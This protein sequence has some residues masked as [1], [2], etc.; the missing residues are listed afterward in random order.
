MKKYILLLVSVYLTLNVFGQVDRSKAPEAGP[1]PKVQIGESQSFTLKNGLKVLVVENHKL[2]RLNFTL[3]LINDPILEGDKSGY[4]E[5][6]GDLWGK[7]TQNRNAKKL[8]EE[9]DFIGA[10]LRTDSHKVSIEG[11]SKFKEDM[12]DIFAD[13]VLN[14]AF[15]KEEFDK[16]ILQ[17]Q[18][19]LKLDET[20]PKSILS[21]ISL[22]TMFGHEH[23]YGDIITPKTVDNISLEDCVNYYKTYVHPNHSILVIVGDITLKDAKKLIQKYMGKWKAASIPTYQYKRPEAPKGRQVVF[24]NK[25]AAPQASIQVSYPIDFKRGQSDEIAVTVM[26]QVLGGGGFQGKLIK[27]LRESK[28]YTYGAFSSI[29]TDI[30]DGAGTFSASAEVKT[31]IVDSAL[32]EILF[33]MDNMVKG[34]FSREDIERIKKTMAGSFSRSMES[35][36]TIANFAFSMEKYKLPKDYFTN[37]L[38]NLS[39]VTRE[40]AV[41]A[42]QKYIHPE[43]AYIFVVTDRGQ[44]EKLAKLSSNGQV[45]ELDHLGEPLKAAAIPAGVTSTTVLDKY[46]NAIGGKEK[47]NGIKDLSIT[48]EMNVQGMTLTII[49]RHILSAG[50]PMFSTSTYMGSNLIQKIS[51]D[52]EKAITKSPAGEQVLE[53]KDAESLKEQ[54]YPIMEAVYGQMGITPTLEGIET[55]NGKNAYKIKFAQGDDITYSFYDAESGLKVKSSSTQKEMTQEMFYEDYQAIANGLLFPFLSKT[56]MR[57]INVEMKTTKIEVNTGIKAGDL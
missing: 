50:K 4:T 39:K 24:S 3:N 21:N 29:R 16:I 12:L 23:P 22:T 1:A 27:N 46:I 51:Y 57:G 48:S 36:S 31:N 28:G 40:D 49:A 10:K 44:K 6:A 30:L 41:A 56:N 15:Q 26:N 9:V 7:S 32:M 14:P 33:E 8:A 2:P 13:V 35:P 52:G 11:L 19:A 42:A 43:N 18:T 47:I 5:I 25:D 20:E 37:Y 45:I 53:G 54:A 38:E 17:S 55:I 34:R